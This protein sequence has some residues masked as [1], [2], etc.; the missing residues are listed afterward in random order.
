VTHF[1]TAPQL[2]GSDETPDLSWSPDGQELVFA[3]YANTNGGLEQLYVVSVRTHHVRQLTRL[4]SG[5]TQPAWSPNGRWIAFVGAVAPDRIY[6]LST[7]THRAH[8]VGNATGLDVAWS[9]DSNRLVFNSKGKLWLVKAT[10]TTRFHSLRVW[11]EQPS[12]SPDG[13]WI[14]FTYGDYVKEIRPDGL[15]IHHILY[16]TSKKGRNFEPSW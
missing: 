6:L 11:G 16:L 14:V 1:R 3:A 8:V 5:A 7:K 12:W 9:P 10:G 15:G 2:F 13:Q 4:S